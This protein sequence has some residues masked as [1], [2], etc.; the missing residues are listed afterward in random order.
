MKSLKN[1][2][3]SGKIFARFAAF[4]RLRTRRATAAFS[5]ALLAAVMVMAALFFAGCINPEAEDVITPPP[6]ESK[7]SITPQGKS[8]SPGSNVDFTAKMTDGS[9]V[10]GVSWKIL[11]THNDSTTISGG[12][13]TVGQDE[14]AEQFTVI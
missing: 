2:S 9:P 10:T 12:K 4:A 6:P 7:L 8:I 14:T 5:A 13:L 3:G 1:G 11:G